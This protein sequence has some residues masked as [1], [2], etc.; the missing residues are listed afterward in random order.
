MIFQKRAQ[1]NLENNMPPAIPM[2]EETGQTDDVETVVGPSVNVEGDLSSNGNIIVK[3]TV[4]G[5]VNTTKQL[6]VE[7]GAKIVANIKAGTAVV[8]GEIKGNIKIKGSL[9]LTSTSKIVGDIDVKD[10]NVE[11]G[12]II[13]GKVAMPG[14]EVEKRTTRLV[15]A[16]R[17]PD[18]EATTL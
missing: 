16:I 1:I 7:K 6:T 13:Y 14:V 10:L 2:A 4:M 3:G 8:A 9:Q 12:A 11:S 18:E 15:R 5:S 17:K